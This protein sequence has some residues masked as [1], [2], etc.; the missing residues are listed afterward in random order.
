MPNLFVSIY[1]S[2]FYK[3][4]SREGSELEQNSRLKTYIEGFDRALEGGI[5]QGHIVLMAGTPGTMK[6]SLTVL[7]AVPS[8]PSRE[9]DRCLCDLGA[10]QEQP[11]ETDGKDGDEIRG[12]QTEPPR[13]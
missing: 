1:S 8:G 11:V 10:V 13:P 3:N 2:Y 12:C 7:H 9:L 5:P 6:S 4:R